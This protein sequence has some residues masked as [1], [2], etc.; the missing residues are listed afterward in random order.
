[1]T[2]ALLVAVAVLWV[3]VVALVVAVFALTRQIGVLY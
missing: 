2:E 1:M 3:L